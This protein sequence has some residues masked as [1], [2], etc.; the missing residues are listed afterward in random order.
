MSGQ[1]NQICLDKGI[2]QE[3]SAPHTPNQNPVEQYMNIIAGGT[4]SL[5]Y[6]S[7]LPPAQYWSHAIEHKVHLQ[8][9]SALPGRCTPYEMSKGT[10]PNIGNIRICGCEAM[11]F[12]EKDQRTKWQDKADKCIYLGISS[13]HTDDTHKLLHLRTNEVI[14]RRNVCFN[15]RS[16]PARQRQLNLKPNQDTGADLIGLQFVDEGTTFI[17]LE[18]DVDTNGGGNILTYEDVNTKEKH[19]S[20]VK[21]VREWYEQTHLQQS[22]TAIQPSRVGFMNR[23]ANATYQAIVNRNMTYSYPKT[24]R[25]Q[26]VTNMPVT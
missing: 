12:A 23:L 10:Q 1:F 22:V 5:S 16:F 11:A 8:N 7:G 14:Y 21:E 17:I 19:Y 24:R 18:T 4:R 6:I 25:H 15:E 3:A 2:K 13:L 20:T 26:R 9:R